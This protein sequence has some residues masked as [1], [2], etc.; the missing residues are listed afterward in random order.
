M[1]PH[2]HQWQ[3]ASWYAYICHVKYADHVKKRTRPGF[4]PGSPV[5]GTRYS[6]T[7][8]CHKFRK[9]YAQRYTACAGHSDLIK[10]GTIIDT[11]NVTPE[12]HDSSHFTFHKSY[13]CH[14]GTMLWCESKINHQHLCRHCNPL[15]H[16]PFSF[17]VR[18]M[19]AG[20]VGRSDN[21]VFSI[22]P[23]LYQLMVKALRDT[24]HVPWY[25]IH[26]SPN[27][28]DKPIYCQH[29]GLAHAM[30][31]PFA[32]SADTHVKKNHFWTWC[33]TNVD[34]CVKGRALAQCLQKGWI[35]Y[36][37]APQVICA[38]HVHRHTISQ[39]SWTKRFLNCTVITTM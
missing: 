36:L 20:G 19:P 27:I 35:A 4:E 15:T 21:I 7:F 5:W 8:T 29:E 32:L 28:S 16:N 31:H 33:W 26:F 10:I 1:L 37:Q 3:E 14:T 17:D 2:G 38:Y 39:A 34:G 12:Y 24:F 13:S 6:I 22:E 23:R 18:C 11:T 9:K 30:S 25:V